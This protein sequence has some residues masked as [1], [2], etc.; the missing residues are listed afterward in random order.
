ME[1]TKISHNVKKVETLLEWKDKKGRDS[2]TL[3]LRSSEPPR[4]ELVT[5]LAAFVPVMVDAMEVPETF[6][7]GLE[8]RSVSFKVVDEDDDVEGVVIASIKTWEGS[9]RPWNH[10]TPL[11]VDPDGKETG[12]WPDDMYLKLAILKREAK[13]FADGDRAQLG[14]ALNEVGGPTGEHLEADGAE[15]DDEDVP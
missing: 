12:F 13:A 14:L 8:V 9:N 1:F 11:L 6:A 5:A 2:R 4:P 3:S 10:I 7:K 15:D